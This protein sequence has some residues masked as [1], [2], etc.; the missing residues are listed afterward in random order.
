VRAREMVAVCGL[1][2]CLFVA[3][4]RAGDPV[5]GA[6]EPRS[7]SAQPAPPRTSDLRASGSPDLRARDA[8]ATQLTEESHVLDRTL[9]TVR[10]KLRDAET[11]RVR[12]LRAAY[13]ILHAAAP[14]DAAPEDRMIAARR[15]AAARWLA[16]RDT[17]ERGLLAAETTRLE[18]AQAAVTAAAAQLP[19]VTLPTELAWP[20]RGEIARKFGTMVHERS[21][22]TLARHGLDIEVETHAVVSAPAD[23]VVRYAGPIR[24]LDAGVILDHGDTFIVVAKL[25][26]PTIPVGAHVAKGDRLGHA[27]R[28]RVYLE[29]RVKV[30]P[31]GLPIDPEPLLHR[32]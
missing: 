28:H 25:G 15:R 16:A 27:A 32:E 24:R 30:G 20:A 5:D 31:G 6:D 29:V 9:E 18:T 11:V 4:A 14:S 17:S 7:E 23:G 8:L 26:D 10:G 3:P 1:S 21:N 13:R 22:A 2:A 19:T 12:R